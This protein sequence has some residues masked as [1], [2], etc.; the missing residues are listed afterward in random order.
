MM[1]Y[2]IWYYFNMVVLTNLIS[3]IQYQK[4]HCVSEALV[5]I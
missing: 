5:L 2:I 4:S 1:Q 3:I